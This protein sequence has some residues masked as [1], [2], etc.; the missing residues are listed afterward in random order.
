MKSRNRAI[1]AFIVLAAA[2]G[3]YFRMPDSHQVRTVAFLTIFG[4]GAASAVLIRESIYS[5]RNSPGNR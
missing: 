5:L 3:N 1:A 4:I 2:L